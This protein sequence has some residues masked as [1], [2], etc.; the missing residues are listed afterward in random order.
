MCATRAKDD[1]RYRY[2]GLS[3]NFGHQIAIT[4]GMERAQAD[5]MGMLATVMNALVMQNSLESIG[6][7]PV[8]TT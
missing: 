6:S 7:P 2:V 5:H 8:R 4:A 1:P 3:R